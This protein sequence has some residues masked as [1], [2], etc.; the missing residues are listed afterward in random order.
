MLKHLPPSI[1]PCLSMYLIP[2]YFL[3]QNNN[4]CATLKHE[5]L[6]PHAPKKY[7]LKYYNLES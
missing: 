2:K 4:N 3:V 1:S 7:K 5:T 6:Q